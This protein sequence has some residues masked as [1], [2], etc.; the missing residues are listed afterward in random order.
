[1]E[2][3]ADDAAGSKM[4]FPNIYLAPGEASAVTETPARYFVGGETL[5]YTLQIADTSVAEGVITAEGKALFTGVGE[6][7]TTASITASN[8]E[9]QNFNITVR[10]G[11]SGSGWL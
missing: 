10:K 4:T 7:V 6:G 9:T 3:I 5:T 1:M 8:G 11:A 2:A